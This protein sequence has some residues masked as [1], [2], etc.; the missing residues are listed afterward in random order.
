MIRVCIVCEGATE[1]EFVSRCITPYLLNHHVH[2][3]PSILQSPSGRHRGGRV[4]VDRLV[5]YMAHEYS[6]T[7][8]ITSFVDFYGFTDAGGRSREQLEHDIFVGLTEGKRQCDPRYV[9]P[10]VQMHEFEALLFSDTEQFQFVL[11]GWNDKV[12]ESLAEVRRRFETPEHINNGPETAPSKRILSIFEWGRYSKVEHGPI[13]AQEIGL[14]RIRAQCPQF[15]AW[16]TALER[17]GQ[18]GET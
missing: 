12:R 2:A 10:Y 14:P 7:D 1:V 9:L 13:I 8:R 11:D 17:W 18:Q 15:D 5:N 16:L 4:T 3:Y 6:A